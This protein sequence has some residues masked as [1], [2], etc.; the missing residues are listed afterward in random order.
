MSQPKCAAEVK[1]FVSIIFSERKVL[2]EA[3]RSLTAQYGE[4]DF[5]SPAAPFLYTDYYVRE[6]GSP[7][8]RLF[9]SFT[10]LIRPESLPDVKLWTNDMEKLFSTSGGRKLNIDPGYLAKGHLILAT[11]K[12]YAHR[13][14]LRDG[15]FADLTLIYQ[16]K[17]FQALPWTY[18]D[19]G[20]EA[21]RG[22]FNRIREKYLLQLREGGIE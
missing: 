16:D 19:Y 2:P 5:I 11:G 14:Y 20:E 4:T 18:P 6:M 1:L 3:L 8:E 22:M 13:P 21:T 15:I 12:E 9:A 7:L 10:A 17:S